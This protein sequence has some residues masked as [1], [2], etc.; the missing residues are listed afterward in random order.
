MAVRW[1]ALTSRGWS[2]HIAKV[3]VEIATD[4]GRSGERL[5]ITTP[6]GWHP[7]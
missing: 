6:T 3:S 1:A 5:L 4:S 7:T 2:A